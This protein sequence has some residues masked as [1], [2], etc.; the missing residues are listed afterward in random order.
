MQASTQ[1]QIPPAAETPTSVTIVGADGK[2]QS[3]AIPHTRAEIEQLRIRRRELTDQLGSVTSRRHGLS[4][5]I[6]AAP[7]GASRTGLEGRLRVLDQRILQL[8]SDVAATGQQ[9]AAAPAELMG[10]MDSESSLASVSLRRLWSWGCMQRGDVGVVDEAVDLN[11]LERSRMIQLGS[12]ASRM[13][14]KQSQLKW[15]EFQRVSAS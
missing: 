2:T 11:G 5:E 7:E 12:N 9:I 1:P 3:L 14:S 8:E 13:E 10:S 6:R 15:S 4:E